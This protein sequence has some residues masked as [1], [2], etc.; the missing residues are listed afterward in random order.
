MS[1]THLS[2]H[3]SQDTNANGAMLILLEKRMNM[4]H[5][6]K[7]QG[8]AFNQDRHIIALFKIL[9]LGVDFIMLTVLYG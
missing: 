8:M 1:C 4:A 5:L 2:L 6:H 3:T 9:V 7:S